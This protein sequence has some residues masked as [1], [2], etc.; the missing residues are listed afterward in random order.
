MRQT[1]PNIVFLLIVLLTGCQHPGEHLDK[2][3]QNPPESAKPWVFWYWMHA[4]VS[5][6]GITADLEAMKEAGIGG[7][8]LMPIKD[9]KNPP[10]YEPAA[11]QLS[12]NFWSMVKHAFKEADRLELKIAMH[13]SDG[14]ALAGGPWITP[15]LSMQKVVW[16][17]TFVNG[18]TIFNNY[19]PKPETIENYYEDI[20]VFAYPNPNNEQYESSF[21]R[22]VETTTNNNNVN[23]NFLAN[24]PAKNTFKS[25]DSCW[26]QF[27]FD[28]PFTCRNITIYTT[29]TN[30]QAH[31]LIIEVSNDGQTFKYHTR[32]S[33][34]RHGWQN[35]DANVTHAIPPVTSKYFRFIHSLKGTEPGAEDLDA[36]KWSPT[37]KINSI[38]LKSEPLIHQ[39]ESKNGSVWR[40]S[41]KTSSDQIDNSLCI[42][43]NKIIDL[44]DKLSKKGH[45]KWDIPNGNW[46]IIRIGHTSTGHTNYTGGGG[47]GLECDKYN[48][49][50]VQ[51]QWDSWFGEAI[52]QVGPKLAK[53]VLST[54]H[55]DS[56]E[57]G[58][59]NWSPAF[60]N[61]FEKRRGYDIYKYM[62]VFAG[63]PIISKDSTERILADIRQTIID[64]TNDIFYG[65]LAENCKKQGFQF[66][67][68][69]IAPTMMSDGLQHYSKVT[70]PMGEFWLNSPTH[71]KPN[72]M[73][74]A[75][76]GAHI[77]NKPIVQ[78]ESFTTVRM[79]W[80]EHPGMLKALGDR[81]FALG[82]NRLVFHVF[83]HNPWMDK[84]PGMTLDGVGLYFQRDQTWWKPG[85]EWIKYIQRCQALLQ[86][87]DHVADIAV[88]IGEEVPRRSILPDRL[89]PVLPGLF[90]HKV[91]KRENKRLLNEGQPQ[92]EKPAGVNHSANIADP[93]DWAN[94]LNGYK[95]DSFNKDAFIRL[96]KVEN[97]KVSFGNNTQYSILIFPGVRRMNP[98]GTLMS[99]EIAEKLLQIINDG[100][101]VI[102]DF[103]PEKTI[104]FQNAKNDSQRL[105]NVVDEIWSCA[106]ETHNTKYGK[107]LSRKVGKGKVIFSPYRAMNFEMIGVSP[108]VKVFDSSG[109]PTN[110]IAYTHRHAPSGYDIYFISNQLNENRNIEV[111]L[112]CSNKLP[113]FFDPVNG[114]IKPCSKWINS[115]GRTNI[116]LKM[117][118]NQSIFIVLRKP[119]D[120]S[121]SYSEPEY[122]KEISRKPIKT[123][124][125]ITF[126]SKY[127]GP[128]DPFISDTLFDWTKSNNNKIKY[129]SGTASYKTQFEI[130]E[131]NIVQHE[132]FLSLGNV[133]NIAEVFINGKQCGI[134]WTSPMEINITDAARRGINQ[135]EIKVTNTWANRL[136]G[137]HILPKEQQITFTTAPYRLN[138]KPLLTSGLIGPVEIILKNMR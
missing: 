1:I 114:H 66:T 129:Y 131:Y 106:L 52:N 126:N 30:Y 18:D 71:D 59:Q 90:D 10:L 76:S 80:S 17:K 60:R 137:D 112:R 5:K 8:Y 92:N 14:F 35:N 3:F 130:K 55:V 72:D 43:P 134:L 75:I 83:T 86:Q 32:L 61:E 107:I 98:N 115:M 38:E 73:L 49:K 65:T 9:V 93:T 28:K 37:L 11:I 108:D 136:I 74:D 82:I 133:N 12:P 120:E 42:N 89:V 62:P 70:I 100:A 87:G 68:E 24:A 96:A 113:E 51:L 116:P 33:C 21:N 47:L 40:I 111:S 34:P 22:N 56:W 53:K 63:I 122:S 104:S 117:A 23:A 26:I 41:P 45:L 67:A 128:K 119:T 4:A 25:K 123:P 46:T 118:P 91:L 27:S 2:L 101:T 15:E 85:K 84:M 69:A 97:G 105:K 79:D 64:L 95:Y 57:C 31:R 88:F 132:I 127:G 99:A 19:L 54:F 44:T 50:A 36:A 110:G 6:K 58:S 135:L 20:A 48:T 29:G 94:A 109:S 124:W 138:E 125:A 13:A 39:F 78:A 102:M 7:A 16:S 81:N 121:E 77:Y 103:K